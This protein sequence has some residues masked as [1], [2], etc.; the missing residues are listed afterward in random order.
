MMI[1]DLIANDATAKQGTY[2]E[3][4]DAVTENDLQTALE[5]MAA[6]LLVLKGKRLNL[7][8]L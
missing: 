5:D 3:N 1:I 4:M 8:V 2:A 6:G 7:P